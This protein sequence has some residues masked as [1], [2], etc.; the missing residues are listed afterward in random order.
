M[1]F[2]GR[3]FCEDASDEGGVLWNALFDALVLEAVERHAEE[4]EQHHCHEAKGV[5]LVIAGCLDE[6][7]QEGKDGTAKEEQH[8]QVHV[9]DIKIRPNHAQR[10]GDDEAYKSVVLPGHHRFFSSLI[11]SSGFSALN[12]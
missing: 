8:R 1:G 2:L 5:I 10:K 11:L 3:L 9:S 7:E 4:K 6:K 12:T